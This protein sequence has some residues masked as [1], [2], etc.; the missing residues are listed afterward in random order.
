[1]YFFKSLFITLFILFAFFSCQTETGLDPS[2]AANKNA[3][4]ATFSSIEKN[5]FR[6]R[7]A[8]SGCHATDTRSAGMDL[9]TNQAYSNL[10]GIPSVLSVQ[11]L[12]RVEPFNSNASFLIKVLD[13]SNP[14]KMPLNSTPLDNA[15]IDKIKQWIDDGAKNN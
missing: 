12:N 7:C 1:M 13:G 5:V 2:A 8:L 14:T 4:T 6:V 3:L 10:V 11:G 9:S 15:T